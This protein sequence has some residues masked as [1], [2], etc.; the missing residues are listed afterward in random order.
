MISS[1]VAII[2]LRTE[3]KLPSYNR[4]T[5]LIKFSIMALTMFSTIKNGKKSGLYYIDATCL[6]VCHISIGVN[7]IKCLMGYLNLEKH[8]LANFL[9]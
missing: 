6:P 8:L 5:E 7:N 1:I 3:V 9:V 4:F 2:K